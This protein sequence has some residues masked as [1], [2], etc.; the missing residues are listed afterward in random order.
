MRDALAG[1]RLRRGLLNIR[2]RLRLV[3]GE[4]EID[5]VPGDGARMT[6]TAPPQVAPAGECRVR[7]H[8]LALEHDGQVELA[9][10]G[11]RGEGHL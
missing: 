5:S 10:V 11:F 6:I 2:R 8:S 4:L 9:H 3:G 7:S 1:A